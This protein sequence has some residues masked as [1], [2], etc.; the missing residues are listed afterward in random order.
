L[1]AACQPEGEDLLAVGI[2]VGNADAGCHGT[3]V[4]G[5]NMPM[6]TTRKENRVQCIVRSDGAWINII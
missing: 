3:L 4:R 5:A 1:P 2:L 6:P